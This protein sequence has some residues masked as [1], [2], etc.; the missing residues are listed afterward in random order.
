MPRNPSAAPGPCCT[1]PAMLSVLANY[2][3]GVALVL[4]AFTPSDPDPLTVEQDFHSLLD[5]LTST[6]FDWDVEGST[7]EILD[8]LATLLYGTYNADVVDYVADRLIHEAHR[9]RWE[10]ALHR[11]PA[12]N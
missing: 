2:Q 3:D 11:C 10:V 4:T 6:C 1:K 9:K 8:A 12:R 5:Y 7:K